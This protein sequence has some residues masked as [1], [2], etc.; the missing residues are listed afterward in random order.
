[1]SDLRA[2]TDDP[3]DGISAALIDDSDLYLWRATITGPE[4]TSWEGGIYGLQ[5][6]FDG[7]YPD[8][9]PT[10]RFVCD[11]FHPNIY[12]DGSLCMDVLKSMWKPVF[13]VGMIL[14]SVQSL[15][16]DPNPLSPANP[17]AA[18]LL[19]SD[20]KAYRRQVRRCAERSLEAG[21]DDE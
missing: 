7:S 20:P 3:P 5:L 19:T 16:S 21:F 14:S 12:T 13:T 11:M 15:L 4:D 18:A 1:M 8:T 6:V 17:A 9:P 10:A 2:L